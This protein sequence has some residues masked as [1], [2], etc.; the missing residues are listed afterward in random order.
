MVKNRK[1]EVEI[2]NV[3]I[4]PQIPIFLIRFSAIM[5]YGNDAFFIEFIN[6]KLKINLNSVP[7]ST[8][9]C[10]AFVISSWKSE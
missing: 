3:T 5:R 8:E 6:L 1:S 2:Y 7:N 4:L 10:N 9:A